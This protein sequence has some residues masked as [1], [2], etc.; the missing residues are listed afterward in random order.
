MIPACI[1][2][3]PEDELYKLVI[4]IKPLEDRASFDA[5]WPN[6]LHLVEGLPGLRREATSQVERF[7]YGQDHYSQMHEL[8]FDTLAEAEQALA[9]PQ[10]QA[11]GKLLQ[12]MTKGRMSLFFAEHK[13]D[14]LAN[15]LKYR[16]PSGKPWPA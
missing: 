4:L 5:E 9:L 7:L 1:I 11:A 8:F 2:E 16:Q 3:A 12:Q 10:G 13:E 6:F 14:D 15:I